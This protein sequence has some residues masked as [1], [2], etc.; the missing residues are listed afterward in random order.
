[1]SEENFKTEMAKLR[2]SLKDAHFDENVYDRD[3][4]NVLLLLKGITLV[5]IRSGLSRDAFLAIAD[6]TYDQAQ[7]WHRFREPKNDY[8]SPR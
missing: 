1:M 6:I 8:G 5:A 7:A 3:I 4:D 2:D